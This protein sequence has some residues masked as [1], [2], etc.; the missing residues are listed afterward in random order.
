[1]TTSASASSFRSAFDAFLV[2][3]VGEDTNNNGM[4]LSVLSAL[5]RQNVD[6]WEEAARLARLS[7]ETATRELTSL[8]AALPDRPATRLDPAAIAAR[9]VAL[10]PH[11]P[12]IDIHSRTTL[13]GIQP[14]NPSWPVKQVIIYMVA[15]ACMLITQ[16]FAINQQAAQGGKVSAPSSS[17]VPLQIQPRSSGRQGLAGESTSTPRVDPRSPLR[18]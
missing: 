12:V 13:A 11:R 6:P 17:Q 5:A 1:M 3:P 14:A 18:P 8:I 2:A 9:L 16:W 15:I 4:Q 7:T 10:L